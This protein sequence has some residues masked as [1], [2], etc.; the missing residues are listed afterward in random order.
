MNNLKCDQK[1]KHD[2]NEEVEK[3]CYYRNNKCLLKESD[4][5]G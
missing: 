5:N 3:C 1:C 2:K 4:K